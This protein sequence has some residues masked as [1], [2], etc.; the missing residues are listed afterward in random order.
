MESHLSKWVSEEALIIKLVDS[1]W[2][3]DIKASPSHETE[4]TDCPPHLAMMTANGK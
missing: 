1:V 4:S 2:P 3:A